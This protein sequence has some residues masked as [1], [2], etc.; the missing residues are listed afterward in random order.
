[1]IATVLAGWFIASIVI[2]SLVGTVIHWG[3][4]D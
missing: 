1:M 4:D 3:M 2:G